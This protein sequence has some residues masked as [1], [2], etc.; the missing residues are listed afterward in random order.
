[1][2][3]VEVG[4]ATAH[5]KIPNIANETANNSV[6]HRGDVVD[7]VAKRVIEVELNSA[8]VPLAQSNQHG[9]IV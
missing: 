2:G 5:T 6:G 9:V 1:M 7:R 8:R 3:D 4:A